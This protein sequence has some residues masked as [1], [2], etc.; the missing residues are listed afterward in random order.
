MLRGYERGLLVEGATLSATPWIHASDPTGDELDAL[1]ALGADRED[2]AH[3]LDPDEVA[4][5]A[6]HGGTT[7]IILRLPWKPNNPDD[8]PFRSMT[9]GVLVLRDGRLLTVCRHE[10][11]VFERA[12]RREPELSRPWPLVLCL[13]EEIAAGYLRHLRTID[14]EVERLEDE[15]QASLRNREVLGL[16]RYQKSLVHFTTALSSIEIVLDRVGRH[17]AP[18][19]GESDASQLED[20]RI[21]VRQ[22]REMC[23]VAENILSQMM[24]AFASIISNNLNV[25]MKVLTAATVI[26]SIPMLIASVYGMNVTLPGQH[27]PMSF[28]AIVLLSFGLSLALAV[29]LRRLRWL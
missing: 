18:A 8:L 27:H 25:V 11:D 2:L 5:L 6:S 24:D 26:L 23:G 3:S 14:A 13:V 19:L 22:A 7:L 10:S 20:A 12:A 4:R 28:G 17:A 21:E 1:V 15:L 9:A 16:L 29:L